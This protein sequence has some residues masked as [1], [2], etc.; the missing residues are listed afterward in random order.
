MCCR[1]ALRLVSDPVSVSNTATRIIFLVH[2]LVFT[3]VIVSIYRR[4]SVP[5]ASCTGRQ[6]ESDSGEQGDSASWL[7]GCPV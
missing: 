4:A 2:V 7:G 1:V 3:L 6:D 5:S